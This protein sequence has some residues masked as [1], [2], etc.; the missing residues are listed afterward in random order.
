M[1]LDSLCLF[2]P[3]LFFLYGEEYWRPYYY[4]HFSGD[5]QNWRI[6][7]LLGAGFLG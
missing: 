4:F 5:I 7:I 2:I 6:K 1:I 3:F